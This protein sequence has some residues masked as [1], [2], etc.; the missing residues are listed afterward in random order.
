MINVSIVH[1]PYN[2]EPL[3]IENTSRASKLTANDLKDAVSQITASC[4]IDNNRLLF[5]RRP[6]TWDVKFALDALL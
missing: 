5:N 3:S 4:L 1:L 2:I 6:L